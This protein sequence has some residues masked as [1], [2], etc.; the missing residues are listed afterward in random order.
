MYIT[1]K[2]KLEE[3]VCKLPPSLS[4]RDIR[5]VNTPLGWVQNVDMGQSP[6]VVLPD[7]I[8]DV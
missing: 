8:Q 2:R 7:K 3:P 4:F 1:S 6:Q 5:L